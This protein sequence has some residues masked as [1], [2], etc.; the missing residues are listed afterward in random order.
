MKN[1]LIY[2][3]KNFNGQSVYVMEKKRTNDILAVH[4]LSYFIFAN[5]PRIDMRTNRVDF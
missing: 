4:I 3:I 1:L 5:T 2:V